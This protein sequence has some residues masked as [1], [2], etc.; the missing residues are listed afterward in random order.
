MKTHLFM[1]FMRGAAI[2]AILIAVFISCLIANSLMATPINDLAY[3]RVIEVHRDAVVFT[4]E[5]AFTMIKEIVGRVIIFNSFLTSV[6]VFLFFC[7][8]RMRVFRRLFV[9]Q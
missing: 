7:L 6:F 4:Q 9:D 8:T 5:I 2:I 1:R 3:A